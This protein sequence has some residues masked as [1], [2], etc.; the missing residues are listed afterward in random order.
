MAYSIQLTQGFSEQ[1]EGSVNYIL[2]T[3]HSPQAAKSLLDAYEQTLH[4]IEQ[5]PTWLPVDQVASTHFD[6][7]IYKISVRSYLL[8]YWV[9][10]ASDTVHLIS[11]RHKSRDY[12]AFMD[13]GIADKN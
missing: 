5:S 13:Q 10:E 2:T 8:R 1:L 9:D 4:L 6:T 12:T 3:L 11:F 7:T